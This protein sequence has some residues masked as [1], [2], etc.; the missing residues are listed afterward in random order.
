MDTAYDFTMVYIDVTTNKR[1]ISK[2]PIRKEFDGSIHGPNN[3]GSLSGNFF[4]TEER[5]FL[6]EGN[7]L[8]G[9]D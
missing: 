3:V 9:R 6:Y 1:F 8:P 4:R 5:K 2:S 7:R